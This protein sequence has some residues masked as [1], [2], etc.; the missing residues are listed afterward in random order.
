VDILKYLIQ[1]GLSIDDVKDSALAPKT[2]EAV[3]KADAAGGAVADALVHR[4]GNRANE[5]EY[6]IR[7]INVIEPEGSIA[8]STLDDPCKLCCEKVMDC[9]LVPCGHQMCCADCGMQLSQCP[10]CKV[11][12]TVLRIYRQ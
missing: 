12:C 10:I 8:S 3:M 6:M 11:Q 2:L 1:K 5:V 9:V 4:E 7:E